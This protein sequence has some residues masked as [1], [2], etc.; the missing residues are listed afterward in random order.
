M[1]T[2]DNNRRKEPAF[3]RLSHRIEMGKRKFAHFLNRRSERLSTRGKKTALICFGVIVTLVSVSLI[4]EPF[5]NKMVNAS[6]FLPAQIEAPSIP[7]PSSDVVFSEEDYLLLT[8]F[9]K[10]LDSLKRY[11]PQVYHEVLK[12]HDGLMDSVNFLLDLYPR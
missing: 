4:I 9:K 12:G 7:K 10:M 3:T 5:R 11:D 2:Q 6:T 1:E 8:G